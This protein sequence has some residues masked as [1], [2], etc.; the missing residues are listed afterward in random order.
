MK[1]LIKNSADVKSPKVRE[2]YGKLAGLVGIISNAVLCLFKILT[3]LAFG[4]VAI[5]ADG[6]NNL[7]DAASSL[8]TFLGFKLAGKPADKDHPYG[9]GR[10]EYM[11]GL[12]VSVMVLAIGFSLL[13]SSVEKTVNPE[14]LEFS[15]LTIV[16]LVA[17]ILVKLWQAS[18]NVAIG[19]LI[20]SEALMA[21][22]ADSRN[23]VI[24]T[25]AVLISVIVNE[26]TEVNVDGPVGILVALFIIWSGIGLVRESTDPILGKAPDPELTKALKEEILSHEGVLGMHDLMIHDYG[27]G[28]LFASVHVEVDADADFMRTHNEIDIIENIVL[29]KFNVLLSCHM[30]PVRLNDPLTEEIKE[31]IE[32]IVS[33]EADILDFHDV[34]VVAGPIHTNVVFDIVLS[35]DSKMSPQDCRELVDAELKKIN[36][37][38]NSVISI[39]R[40]YTGEFS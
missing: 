30:D 20:E 15:I 33:N 34:R 27:P 10:T 7:A 8:T 23:D 25:T 28:R 16:V 14:E 35:L 1:K 26:F 2:S 6:I 31:H 3:G 17:A 11:A 32:S 4:S 12:I 18:F 37:K 9:H 19:R 29:E 24:S 39:D 13:K 38:Y 22:A 40:D 5:L 21:T 36:P